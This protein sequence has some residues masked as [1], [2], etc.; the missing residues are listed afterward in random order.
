MITAYDIRDAILYSRQM[1]YEAR[2]EAVLA[3]NKQWR[4]RL[5][6]I[7]THLDDC[8]G[9]SGFV[10]KVVIQEPVDIPARTK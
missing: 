3:G 7:I 5:T 1:C 8:L 10:E 6:G 9:E 4:D 2:E